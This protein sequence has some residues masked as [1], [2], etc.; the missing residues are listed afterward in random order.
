[1]RLV[2]DLSPNASYSVGNCKSSGLL[3]LVRIALHLADGR[4]SGDTALS[5]SV[6]L[7]SAPPCLSTSAAATAAA[8]FYN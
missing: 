8:D 2:I 1:M 3:K 6:V 7:L 4:A 5:L